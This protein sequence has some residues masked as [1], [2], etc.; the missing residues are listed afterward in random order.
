MWFFCTC[1]QTPKSSS[2]SC[3]RYI[4][5]R[6]FLLFLSNRVRLCFLQVLSKQTKEFPNPQIIKLGTAI[7]RL[8]RI[9]SVCHQTTW[10]SLVTRWSLSICKQLKCGVRKTYLKFENMYCTIDGW[11]KKN[12]I[13]RDATILPFLLFVSVLMNQ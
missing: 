13:I 4:E 5:I 8:N 11:T 6:I 12:K 9:C 7:D 10:R 1:W 3:I 2:F